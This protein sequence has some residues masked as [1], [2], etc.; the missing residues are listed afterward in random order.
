MKE[1]IEGHEGM[2]LAMVLDQDIDAQIRLL[3]ITTGVNKD[4]DRL[5][6]LIIEDVMR[7]LVISTPYT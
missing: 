1:K 3:I 6:L 5:M 7:C 4:Q 2:M